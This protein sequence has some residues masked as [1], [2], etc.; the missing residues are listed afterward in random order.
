MKAEL[1]QS[2]WGYHKPLPAP[3]R[4]EACIAANLAEIAKLLDHKGAL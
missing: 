3:E 4:W 2:C 1:C